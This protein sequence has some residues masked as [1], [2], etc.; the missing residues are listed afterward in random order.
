[1]S[2]EPDAGRSRTSPSTVHS[3]FVEQVRRSPQGI[4][5]AHGS[6]V[7]TYAELYAAVQHAADNLLDAGCVYGDRVGVLSENRPEYLVLQLA[8]ARIGVIVACLNWRLTASELRYCIEL[9]SPRLLLSSTRYEELRKSASPAGMRE[10][11]I[12][13]FLASKAREIRSESVEVDPEAGLLLLYTSGTTGRPKAALISQRAEI[14]RMAVLRMDLGIA[15]T[16]A[17][18]AWSPM[19]HMGGTEHSLAALMSGGTVIVVDGMNAPEIVDAL[20]NYQIGWLLLVPA[21]IDPVLAE[22]RRRNSA[23]RGVRVVGCMA[24]LVAPKLI[25][26][27]SQRLQA[28]FLNSFGAT[29]TGIPPA[30]ADLIGTGVEPKYLGKFLNSLCEARLVDTQ[31]NDVENG[32]TGE[33]IVK[34]PTLFSGY[35]AADSQAERVFDRGWFRMG[36]LFKRD[37]SGRYNFVGRS[38]Y[39][40]KSGGENI[41]PAEIERVLLSDSRVDD[42][43]VVRKSDSK[44]G[45]IPVAFVA[46]NDPS[47]SA[48]EV[49]ALCKKELASYKCPREIVFIA[50]EMLPRSTTGKILRESLEQMLES[51]PSKAAMKGSLS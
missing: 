23:I 33:I 44:W 32:G 24:D 7:L 49:Q 13:E 45:E 10:V 9:V 2:V 46:R 26:E 3:L 31:G 25:A 43:V 22:L 11:T 47:L 18:I 4:A 16:D 37:A 41:Y 14:A 28:P 40:I 19:F 8:A 17:Y 12:E 6:R 48:E 35:W 15:P 29:E 51:A 42:A 50:F 38:K 27:L 20:E 39:L 30:S 1:M 21:T 5:I 34:G 36:D